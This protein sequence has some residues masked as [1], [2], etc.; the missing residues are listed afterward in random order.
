MKFKL[1]IISYFLLL[2]SDFFACQCPLTKLSSEECNKYDIIFRGRIVKD[3]VNG[4][5]G[6]A[7]FEV[8]ELYKG[9]VSGSFRL[10]YELDGDCAQGFM[11]G[12]EWIIYTTYKQANVGNMDWC[13]RSRKY[14]KNEKLDFYA[15]TYGNDYDTEL[16][17]LRNN[18]GLHKPLA[19]PEAKPD[20]QGNQIPT[21]TEFI[22]YLLLSIAGVVGFIFLVKK[23]LK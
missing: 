3:S 9:V 22:V 20:W 7:L 12:E 21:Q 1:L 15:V 23:F 18:L 13:S 4:K 5:R 19:A 14:F 6:E 2:T 16:K 11:V 10:S 17:F 8:T